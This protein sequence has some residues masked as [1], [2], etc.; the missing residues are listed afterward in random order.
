MRNESIKYVFDYILEMRKKDYSHLI[1]MSYSE[2]LKT[3]EWQMFRLYVIIVK[4]FKCELCEDKN[5]KHF[6]IHH[7]S[8]RDGLLAWQY[9]VK[10]MMVLCGFHHKK[11]HMPDLRKKFD[12]M[13]TIKQIYNG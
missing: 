1:G 13:K 3:D 9:D 8:Y 10:D 6:Q 4:G 11:V 12:K 7:K 5:F 2:Q